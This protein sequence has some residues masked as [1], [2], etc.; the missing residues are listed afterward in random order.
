MSTSSPAAAPTSS[1]H[2]KSPRWKSPRL[3]KKAARTGGCTS[4]LPAADWK[5]RKAINHEEHEEHEG[6]ANPVETVGRRPGASAM[7][8]VKDRRRPG[9]RARAKQ[10]FRLPKRAIERFATA[11][12]A[13]YTPT[14]V[15]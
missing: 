6:K 10:A 14:E 2:P 9:R 3:K 15:S 11:Y 1:P 4:F 5:Y 13:D 12:A 7:A 8:S